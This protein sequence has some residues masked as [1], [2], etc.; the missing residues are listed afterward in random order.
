MGIAGL[1]A[2]I[3][4]WWRI[5]K[6]GAGYG[7]VCLRLKCDVCCCLTVSIIHAV[8]PNMLIQ[9]QFLLVFNINA[10]KGDWM[11]AVFKYNSC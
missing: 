6:N 1:S 9:I 8:F 5:G 7:S 3:G 10:E 4:A 11:A 2:R